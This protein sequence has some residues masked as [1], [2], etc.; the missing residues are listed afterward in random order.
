MPKDVFDK[1]LE[2]VIGYVYWTCNFDDYRVHPGSFSDELLKPFKKPSV[3]DLMKNLD[4]VISDNETNFTQKCQLICDI[5][6]HVQNM[7]KQ[8]ALTAFRS[9]SP[10]EEDYISRK[11]FLQ[12]LKTR[13]VFP[14]SETSVFCLPSEMCIDDAVPLLKGH[15]FAVNKILAIN[16]DVKQFLKDCGIGD[17]FTGE[18]YVKIINSL[19]N[20]DMQ[21]LTGVRSILEH[22]K[23]DFYVEKLQ[24]RKI[25]RLP[26]NDLNLY[27]I[28]DL[29]LD[30]YNL[31]GSSGAKMND[32]LFLCHKDIPHDLA[33]FYGVRTK[34][35]MIVSRH[36]KISLK[37]FHQSET[38]CN[39]LR[40]IAE[41][42]SSNMD[43]FKEVLQNADDA[44]ASEVHFIMDQR[45]L[46]NTRVFDEKWELLT[47]PAL[48]IFNDSY[49]T[50][51]DIEGI[52]KLGEGSKRSQVSKIGS[53]GVGFN[54]V[55]KLTDYPAIL[56]QIDCVGD[57]NLCLLDPCSLIRPE[58]CLL[59]VTQDLLEVSRDTFDCFFVRD[60]KMNALKGKTMLRLPLRR[61]SSELSHYIP[62][63]ADVKQSLENLASQCD[64]FLLFLPNVK[65]IKVSLFEDEKL[66]LIGHAAKCYGE[67][68]SKVKEF[69]ETLKNP[70]Y[71]SDIGTRIERYHLRN[72]YRKDVHGK[73]LS[74]SLGCE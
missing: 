16:P 37:A 25:E 60:E 4:K 54:C 6:M 17:K 43:L 41:E 34:R 73:Q 63:L 45:R 59:E 26:S 66:E 64:Q 27:S 14:A 55:Y 18:I 23:Y 7:P 50:K 29:C 65:T 58:G 10:R 15:L 24:E 28:E 56:T 40:R 72:Y 33:R 36:C 52:Q 21:Q 44:G 39:L 38:L 71:S 19:S 22:L 35:G 69:K 42:Y 1:S 62:T 8:N 47:E 2:T 11:R 13:R 30:D 70:K 48:M 46:S 32:K 74:T 53:F 31:E 61:V 9:N 68:E 5:F 20:V 3:E 49:F 67:F 12:Q 57:G 51:T